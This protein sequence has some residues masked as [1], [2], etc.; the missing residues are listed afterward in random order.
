MNHEAEVAV[1]FWSVW[2]K[3]GCEGE[4][5]SAQSMSTCNQKVTGS[6]PIQNYSGLFP[7]SPESPSA[8]R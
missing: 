7:T 5:L 6:T 2:S 4:Y 8:Q 3:D 1:A